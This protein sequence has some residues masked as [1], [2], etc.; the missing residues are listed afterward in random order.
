[1]QQ[2]ESSEESLSCRLSPSV[3]L[4]EEEAPSNKPVP[5]AALLA[6]RRTIQQIRLARHRSV[7]QRTNGPVNAHLISW[8]CKAQNIQ[9]LENIW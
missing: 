9:N 6:L 3:G 7:D 2:C 4:D 1:M 8:P 5:S